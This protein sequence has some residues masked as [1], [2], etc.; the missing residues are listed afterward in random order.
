[1]LFVVVA[2]VVVTFAAVVFVVVAIVSAAVDDEVVF[3]F[4]IN[5]MRGPR[6][7]AHCKGLW[8]I[9]HVNAIDSHAVPNG[10]HYLIEAL[11]AFFVEH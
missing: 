9:S 10:P 3:M 5:L 7:R 8:A 4:C 6:S 11:L 2:V 1:M